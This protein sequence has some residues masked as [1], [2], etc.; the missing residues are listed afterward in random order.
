MNESE[1]LVGHAH[2]QAA[3]IRNTAAQD[4]ENRD[5]KSP[6]IEAES[7][8]LCHAIERNISNIHRLRAREIRNRGLEER[9]AD[10]ITEF[11]GRMTF[12]Y[13]HALWFLVWLALN[14]GRFGVRAF[15]PYP[16]SLL[17]MVVS[18][19]AIFLSTFVLI[20]QNRLSAE[21]DKRAELD[22]H[23]GLL[24]EHELTR[25]LKMLDE[26]QDKLGIDNDSDDELHELEKDTRPEDVLDEIARADERY[27][28][29]KTRERKAAKN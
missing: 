9:A 22:L 29:R 10:V 8:A 3:K 24:T 2:E 26:I 5:E 14:S 17:T 7:P 28:K 18:L 15:D 11:S 23:I 20:S 6:S 19:E 13:V 27:V 1:N 16:Y 4:G 25:V 12:V 21:A